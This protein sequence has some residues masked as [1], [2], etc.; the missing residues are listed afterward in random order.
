MCLVRSDD[1]IHPKAFRKRRRR[2][3]FFLSQA[4]MVQTHYLP[5]TSAS[6]S[7]FC[8]VL[9]HFCFVPFQNHPMLSPIIVTGTTSIMQ[10][11][12]N[13]KF[14]ICCTTLNCG[15]LTDD[16]SLNGWY[17]GARTD[18]HGEVTGCEACI[19]ISIAEADCLSSN[20]TVTTNTIL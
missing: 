20:P 10:T 15:S 16:D 6:P 14:C 2:R 5:M 17:N 9:K 8:F 13:T 12:C 18:A 7:V 4:V 3:H 11:H 1:G 19:I